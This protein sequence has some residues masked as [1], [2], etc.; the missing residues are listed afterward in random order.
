VRYLILTLVIFGV[1]ILPAFGP[2]TW[3]VL[4]FARLQW[5]LNPVALVALGVV[6]AA[7]GRYLLA[8]FARKFK[9]RLPTRLRGNLEDAK[10]LIARKRIGALTLLGIFVLSPLP[11]AQLFLAA[12]LLDLQL[13]PITFAF[14]LG[15][16]VSYSIYVSV[17]TVADQQLGDVVRNAFGSVW[18]I[19]AQ[20]VL[21][22]IVCV[23]PFIRWQRLAKKFNAR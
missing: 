7:S 4:V 22:A 2:P 20:A 13:V 18:S 12:G 10:D 19:A 23:L 11:S 14:V 15:R 5:H 3:A 21:L 17:A 8:Q 1:N 6:S 16:L 9:T